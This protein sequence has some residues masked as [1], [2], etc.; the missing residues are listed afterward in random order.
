MLTVPTVGI[1]VIITQITILVTLLIFVS[2]EKILLV[3]TIVP[4]G[5]KAQIIISTV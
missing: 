3:V 1:L 2:V 4:G 5:R